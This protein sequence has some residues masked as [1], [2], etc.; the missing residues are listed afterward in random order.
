M[1]QE[2]KAEIAEMYSDRNNKTRDIVKQYGISYS[3]LSAIAKEF[4]IPPRRKP[5]NSRIKRCPQCHSGVSVTGALFCPYCGSD[6]RTEDEK[7][8]DR[9][10]WL[11]SIIHK[12]GIKDQDKA[13]CVLSDVLEKLRK[14]VTK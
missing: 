2:T 3:R 14:E 10:V 13:K 8:I 11:L 12:V 1:T 9:V 7:L 4:G 6:I 5:N